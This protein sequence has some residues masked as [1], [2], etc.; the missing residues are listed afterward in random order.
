VTEVANLAMEAA[1]GTMEETDSATVPSNSAM[2]AADRTMKENDSASVS[3]NTATGMTNLTHAGPTQHAWTTC[4]CQRK[5][6]YLGN[7]VNS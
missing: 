7:N 5:F 3:S 4:I 2:E 1:D 6:C